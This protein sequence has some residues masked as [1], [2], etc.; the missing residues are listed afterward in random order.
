MAT[1][2][3]IIKTVIGIATAKAV[4]GSQRPLQTNDIVFQNETILT[5]EFGAVEI[6]L[7][8]GSLVDLGRNSETVLDPA[9]LQVKVS[10]QLAAEDDV[11]TLQEAILEGTDPTQNSEPTAA[12]SNEQGG[13]EGSTIIQV[14]HNAPETTPTSGFDTTGINFAFPEEIEII[15]DDLPGTDNSTNISLVADNPT[16][17]ANEA[18]LPTGS[19][20]ASDSETVAGQLTVTG[21]NVTYAFS[22]GNNGTGNN[23]T[24]TLNIDGSFSYTLTSS[25][26]SGTNPGTNTVNGVETFNYTA[27]DANGNTTTGTITIDVIDDVPAIAAN[28]LIRLDDDALA[29]GNPGGRGDNPDNQ[30][31]SGTLDHSYGADGEGTVLLLGTGAPAGFVYTLN[32]DGTVMTVSQDGTDV[33]QFTLTDTTSG[34]YTVTQLAPIDHRAGGREN[35]QNFNINYQVTDGDGDTANGRVRVSADDDTP[36]VA[37]RDNPLIRLDDDALADGNP[38][39]RGDNPDSQNAS[40]TLDHSYG[41]DGEGTVLLLGTGAPAGFV[42]TLNG[43]GTVM[44]VNQDGTDILQ[45]TLTDTT[46]G[47]YT[48]TQLAPIDHRAGGRE[49]NQSF[50]INYQVTDG[51]GDT[52][53]GRVRISADDDTPVVTISEDSLSDTTYS[54]TVTN[55]DD[56]SSASYHSSYGYY[57]KDADGNP[58][59]GTVIWDDV[60]DNDTVPVSI[61][62]YSPEQIGFFIIPNG[63][64]NNASLTDNTDVTFQFIDGQWQAF[65]GANPLSGNGSHVLFDVAAL[66]ADGQDHV[67]DN[68]LTGNQNWEDLQIPNGDGDYNDVNINVDWT[69]VT[70]TGDS[71]DTASFGADG[72]KLGADGPGGIDFTL[73]EVTILG[74]LTS[75]GKAVTFE[76]RDTDSD[77]QNDAVF[78]STED[79]DVLSIE[80]ILEPGEFDIELFAPIDSANDGSDDVQLT[81][82]LS[83][84]DNDGDSVFA[85]LNFNLDI[86]QITE[87]IQPVPD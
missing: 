17:T 69:A 57:I 79:G 1:E 61:Q 52:A 13:N 11:D 60:H 71:I 45:F 42:Y 44:T 77:G 50:N 56:V 63:E 16:V 15:G 3:G 83:V 48:V 59:T 26:D 4:D 70:A 47:D 31:A 21:D 12:G 24:L 40:G 38:G 85:T 32:G 78:G 46:S 41:A 76:A 65:D 87:A 86:N 81:A 2:I 58:T 35:N 6:Q 73:E 8:D 82:N 75:N 43:D 22:S 66:N 49:N 18:G 30:N 51:D 28:P 37:S 34:D 36:V 68:A 67:T 62:G 55:H 33:L 10:E 14:Q 84:T 74:D 80:G 20:A 23:G 29:D 39:G 64:N 5:G 27:T 25:V 72:P 19:D 54:F 53:N 7:P 9:V